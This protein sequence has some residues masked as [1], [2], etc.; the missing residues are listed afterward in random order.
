MAVTVSIIVPVLDE[1]DLVVGLLEHLRASFGS[2]EIVVADGGS[3][4]RTVER[5]RDLASIVTAPPGRGPQAG[6]GAAAAAGDVLWFVHVDTRLAPG[7][8]DELR[9][10]LA[11]PDVVGGGFRIRFDGPGAALRWLEWTSNLRARYLHWVFGDQAMFVRREH[12]AAAG[13]FGDLVLME[14]LELSRRLNRHGRLVLLPGPSAAS[15]RRFVE[16]GTVRM[17]VLMQWCK[18][19]YFLGVAPEEIRRRYT[20][21]RSRRRRRPVGDTR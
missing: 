7:A 17:I 16:T 3:R 2:C 8:L 13:G 15:A 12:F 21:V 20:A 11:D 10:A 14:D 5:A 1:E 4:D 18:L 9:A 19:L 6:A